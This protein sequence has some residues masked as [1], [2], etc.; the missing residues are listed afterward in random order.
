MLNGID[1]ETVDGLNVRRHVLV[2]Q[3]RDSTQTLKSLFPRLHVWRLQWCD[4]DVL[5]GA[6]DT[7]GTNGVRGVDIVDEGGRGA[8]R[9]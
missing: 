7:I 1:G 2:V 9:G 8:G 4:W 6:E 3:L 5:G